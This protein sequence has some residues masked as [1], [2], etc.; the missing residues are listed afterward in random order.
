MVD[1]AAIAGLTQ[2]I[3]AIRQIAKAM[4]DIRDAETMQSRAAD[5]YKVAVEALER[6]L[7]ARAAQ[8]DLIEEKRALE[9]QIAEFEAWDREKE[10]YALAEVGAGA[11]VYAVKEPHRGAEPVHW[12]C[13]A[14]YQQRKKSI[15]QITGARG[16]MGETQVWGCPACK[17]EIRVRPK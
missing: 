10:R 16:P 17:A 15:L 11:L 6:A 7:D 3:N 8:S 12:L 13:A 9:A 14:C 5:L 4:L 1:I 2:S